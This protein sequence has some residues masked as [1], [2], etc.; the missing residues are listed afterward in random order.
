[1]FHR[2]IKLRNPKAC[3]KAED[4]KELD[5]DDSKT[6]QEGLVWQKI[7]A[8]MPTGCFRKPFQDQRPKCLNVN[9]DLDE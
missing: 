1:M 9:V 2:E 7:F 4:S 8:S 3:D 6:V 5:S